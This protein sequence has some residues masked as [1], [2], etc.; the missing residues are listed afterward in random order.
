[1]KSFNIAAYIS[2]SGSNLRA[3]I[4]SSLSGYISS[5]VRL[6][7]ANKEVSGLDHPK[8]LGIETAVV[9][10]ELMTRKEFLDV[11]IRLLE[12]HGIDLIV[13]AGFLKKLPPEIVDKYKGR[14]LN[15]HPALLPKFGGKGMHGMA[16]HGAVVAAGEKYSGPTVH[17]VDNK[18]DHGEILIQ[19]KIE[20]TEGETAETLQ[21]KVLEVEH[22]IYPE[23][24]KLLEERE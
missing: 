4:D 2:G 15:I 14:I 11:Q 20:L 21:K 1:M 23:A 24:I 13:L 7:I 3:V 10:R 8:E 18:Y 6:V 9:S 16:V 12:K 19:R 17:F 22:I 5:Q